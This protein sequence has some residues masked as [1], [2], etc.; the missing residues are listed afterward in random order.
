MHGVNLMTSVSLL[1]DL[2]RRYDQLAGNYD[3]LHRR[4]LSHAGGEAQ[5]AL[6]ALVRALATPDSRFL[7]AGCGTGALVRRLIAEGISPD[8]MTLMD[9]STAMLARCADIPARLSRGRLE[10]LPFGD[11]EFDI[12]TCAWALETVPDADMVLDE[13]SR[14]VRK[15]GVL[16]LTFCADMPRR[17]VT[18]FIMRK[19]LLGRRTGQFLSRNNVIHRLRSSGQFDVRAIPCSGPAATLL[20]RRTFAKRSDATLVPESPPI[21][22]NPPESPRTLPFAYQLVITK[23]NKCAVFIAKVTRRSRPG[24]THNRG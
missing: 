5:A 11:E 19:A 4:W 18:D 15:G 21:I 1:H 13:L 2:S 23:D 3:K 12:V 17:G 14:V 9:A 22:V 6:E 16:C 10:A 20:A 24:P 7:D 8:R